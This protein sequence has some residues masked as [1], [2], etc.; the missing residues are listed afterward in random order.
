MLDEI[1]ADEVPT[2]KVY[3][4][5]DLLDDA[6]PRID[7]DEEGRPVRVWVSANTGA[8]ID[9]LHEAVAELLTEE[10]VHAVIALRHEQSRLRALFYEE[11]AVLNEH[12]NDEGQCVVEVRLQASD[13]ERMLKRCGVSHAELLIKRI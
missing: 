9:L 13:F 11:K 7:R 6:S 10:V 4:K 2:L 5:L 8:G 1:G 12:Y 3:N